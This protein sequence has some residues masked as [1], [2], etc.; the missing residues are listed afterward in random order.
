MLQTLKRKAVLHQ[1]WI[2]IVLLSLLIAGAV[3]LGPSAYLLVRGAEYVAPLDEESTLT[4]A[5][6]QGGYVKADVTTLVDYYAQT[7]RSESSKKDTIASREYLMP[8]SLQNGDLI[9]MGLEVPS[10]LMDDAEAVLA[11]TERMLS[12]EDNSYQWDG[13]YVTVCGTV[14]PMDAETEGLYRSYLNQLGIEDAEIG[15]GGDCQFQPLVLVHGQVGRLK[16]DN[17]IFFC[18]VWL[19]LLLV[20]LRLIVCLATGH[21]QKQIRDYLAAMEDPQSAEQHLD[22]FYED[23]EQQGN[24]RMDRC[25]LLYA[26]CVNSWVLSGEDVVWA[27]L[28]TITRKQFGIITVG[29]SYMVQVYGARENKKRRC[30]TIQVNS[31]EQA[32]ELLTRIGR[33]FP[34]AVIGYSEERKKEYEQDPAAFHR[35]A[36]EARMQSSAGPIPGAAPEETD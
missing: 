10:S 3:W 14:R 23:T 16:K 18:I 5:T 25:W 12:D 21:D 30:H 11:D 31:E 2:V 6:L 32:D 34:Y 8:V 27:Y 1:L 7:V 17:L 33:T 29:R 35:H 24:V 13:F 36:M 15:L 22:L 4:L 26:H 20:L 28:Y 9:Y 19:A